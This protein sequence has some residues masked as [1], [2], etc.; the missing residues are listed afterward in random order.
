MT[1]LIRLPAVLSRTGLSRSR[2][3]E[4]LGRNQ[5]PR[6]VKLSPNGRTVVWSDAEVA[7]WIEAR[8]ADREVA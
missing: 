2:L 1:T 6:P 5:F 8:L 4:L 3:Y 7:E